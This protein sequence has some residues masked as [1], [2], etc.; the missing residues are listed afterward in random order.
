ME[1]ETVR[2]AYISITRRFGKGLS[3]KVQVFVTVELENFNLENQ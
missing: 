1:T 2:Q 3:C